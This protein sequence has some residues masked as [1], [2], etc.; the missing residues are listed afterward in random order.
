MNSTTRRTHG[1]GVFAGAIGFL[2][3]GDGRD[4]VVAAVLPITMEVL[5]AALR[6]GLVTLVVDPLP[7]PVGGRGGCRQARKAVA[8]ERRGPE[9]AVLPRPGSGG[10]GGRG[11]TDGES[12]AP[13]GSATGGKPVALVIGD[14]ARIELPSGRPMSFHRRWK[15]RAFVRMAHEWCEKNK[16]DTFAWQV[17]VEKYNE[18]FSD[19]NMAHRR[20]RSDRVDDDLFKGQKEE[21]GELFEF[22]DRANGRLRFRVELRLSA[23]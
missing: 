22:V 21:F 10:Q 2:A 18:Q 19:R 8:W 17:L 16:T 11:G 7:G 12:E 4:A 1:D 5:K 3:G 20:I 15:R 6:A 23:K 14:F 13:A 9:V